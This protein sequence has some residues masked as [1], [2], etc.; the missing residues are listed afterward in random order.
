LPDASII[1]D[2]FQWAQAM[3]ALPARTGLTFAFKHVL[4]TLADHQ[5]GKTGLCNPKRA[6]LAREAAVSD[7]TVKRAIAAAERLGILERTIGRGA[8]VRSSYWLIPIGEKKGT[9]QTPFSQRKGDRPDQKKGTGQTKKGGGPDHDT[10]CNQKNQ[11]LNLKEEAAD[12]ERKAVHKAQSRRPTPEQRRRAQQ[13]E[14]EIA[15]L[16]GWESFQTLPN[17]LVQLL[18]DRW[19]LDRTEVET[20][21]AEHRHARPAAGEAA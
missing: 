3:R 19:P 2:R 17:E 10:L 4:S 21:I 11:N 15:G 14:N 13:V 6:S 8:G 1:A 16:I 18:R 9:G 12:E 7:R 20:L 5:N